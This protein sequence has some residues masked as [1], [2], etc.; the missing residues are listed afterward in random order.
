MFST[1]NSTD[2]QI[3]VFQNLGRISIN[4]IA[5]IGKGGETKMRLRAVK[6]VNFTCIIFAL[7]KESRFTGKQLKE[8]K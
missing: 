1:E 8:L 6:K 2:I 7:Y 3:N 4:L 5:E